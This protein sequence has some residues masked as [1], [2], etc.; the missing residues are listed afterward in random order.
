MREF[1]NVMRELMEKHGVGSSGALVER[2]REVGY[3]PRRTDP[4][5]PDPNGAVVLYWTGKAIPPP[6]FVA[7]FAN[8]LPLSEDDGNRLFR[9]YK[10]QQRPL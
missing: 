10:R 1:A 4:P 8:A 6:D 3:S 5:V 7:A 9:A 2:L